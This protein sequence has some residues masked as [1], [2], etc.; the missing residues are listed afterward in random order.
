MT[1]D[2]IVREHDPIAGRELGLDR[3]AEEAAAGEAGERPLFVEHLAGDEGQA[4]QL[5]VR[6]RERGARLRGRGSRSPGCSG[7]WAARHVRPC[8]P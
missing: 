7:C 4:Q 1:T 6:M 5:T 3:G 8:A 2:V